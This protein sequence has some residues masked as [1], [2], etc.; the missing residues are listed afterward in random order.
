MEEG[1]RGGIMI[2]GV[3][4]SNLRYADNLRN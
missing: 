3:M 1:I 4:I 2:G